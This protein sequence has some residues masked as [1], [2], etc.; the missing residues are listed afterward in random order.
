MSESAR[1]A[2]MSEHALR[3]ILLANDDGLTVGQLAKMIGK[4]PA[5]VNS[6]LSDTYGFYVD[7]WTEAGSTYAPVWC[8]VKVPENCPRPDWAK[9]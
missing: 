9:R 3:L 5:H 2:K 4:Q 7:R 6:V 8:I 1:Q